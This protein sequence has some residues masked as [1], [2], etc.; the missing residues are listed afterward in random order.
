MTTM[1]ELIMVQAR[2]AIICGTTESY[3]KSFIL[4]VV[5]PIKQSEDNAELNRGEYHEIKIDRLGNITKSE[6]PA[7]SL[8]LT[9][10]C[11]Q[12]CKL[13][14]LK[15]LHTRV[16]IFLLTPNIILNNPNIESFENSKKD[17]DLVHQK[18]FYE[19]FLSENQDRGRTSVW[20]N[21]ALMSSISNRSV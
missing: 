21:S 3:V 7:F 16:L 4:R 15:L 11:D 1:E 9:K 14:N 6:A 5:D 12:N 2:T 13:E 18:Q 20:E 19:K 8:R 17:E 10:M